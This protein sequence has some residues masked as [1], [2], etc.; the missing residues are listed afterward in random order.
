MSKYIIIILSGKELDYSDKYDNMS[1]RVRED[2]DIL[3]LYVEAREESQEGDI[4]HY[5]F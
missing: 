3:I 5:S 4:N 2:L 1:L